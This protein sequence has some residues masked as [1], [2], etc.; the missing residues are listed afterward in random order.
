MNIAD[1]K[2]SLEYLVK[3]ELTPFIWGHAGIGKS[4]IVKQFAE[5]KGFHFFPFY[6]GTQSD[7]GDILGLAEFV[8]NKDGTKSTVFAIPKWLQDTIQYCN[9]NPDSGA[10]IFL[11]EFNRA[12][13]DILNGM[14]SL[15]LDKTFHTVKLPKNCHIIAAGNPPTDEYFT[16]DVNET[17]LMARFVHVKLEPTVAEWLNYAKET[18]V[19]S[20]L[21]GFIKN[22]PDLL[23]EKHSDFNLSSMVKPD[24]RAISR[25]DRLFKLGTPMNLLEQLMHGIIGLERTVAYLQYCKYQDKPLTAVEILTG[26]CMK[27]V[28]KWS[29]PEDIQASFLNL[30]CD[31]IREEL[32]A[33]NSAAENSKLSDSEKKH[34]M[35]FL[36]AIPKDISYP[37]IVSLVKASPQ[38]TLFRDFHTGQKYE[39]DIEKLC[40]IAVGGKKAKTDKETTEE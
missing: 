23:E 33:R 1:F 32:T 12:R 19:E 2:A 10:I 24:R 34:L 6:L 35:N 28:E 40:K 7:I 11:D 5:S 17:A 13:R 4:S 37:L 18:K 26:K 27:L 31:N 15:A 20:S 30:S 29:N 25:L 39:A 9:D 36:L 22:Q 38:N 16:T 14:F 3:A 21:I 8:D